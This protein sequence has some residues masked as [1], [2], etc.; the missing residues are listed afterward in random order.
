MIPRNGLYLTSKDYESYNDYMGNLFSDHT[1]CSGCDKGCSED[2]SVKDVTF[3]LTEKCNLNCTYCYEKH[4]TNRRMT[5][6]VAKAGVDF[7]FNQEKINGYFSPDKMNACILEFIGGEPL[8]ETELMD[9]I[10]EYFKFKAF[11]EGHPWAY[12]YRISISS[13]GVL[14]NDEKVQNFI[15]KNKNNISMS[16]SVDGNKELHDACRVFPNGTGSYDLASDALKKVIAMGLDSSTKMTLAPGNI[17]Y[18]FEAIK[19]LKELGLKFVFANCVF[20][21]G[22]EF[23]HAVIFYNELKKI[24]DWI[25]DNDLHTQFTTSLFDETI[26]QKT[27][28]DRN[29]CGGNGQMLAIGTDGKCYPCIRFMNYSLVNQPEQC[30]GDIYKGLDSNNKWLEKLKTITMSSQSSEKCLNCKIASGC[31]LC[32]AYNYDKFGDPNVRATFICDMHKARVCANEYFWNKLYKK[33]GL[34]KEFKLNMENIFE[35]R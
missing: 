6:E 20:E 18:T 29:W 1:K 19:N 32:T 13:N 12:N 9:Y 11:S 27:T 10:V 35:N 25:L 15:K 17:R 23:E 2:L 5:K 21:E 30:I 16:I 34:K 4:K 26:G 31:A 33:L 7:L 22:W 8:L 3:V 14:F 24:A 28:E